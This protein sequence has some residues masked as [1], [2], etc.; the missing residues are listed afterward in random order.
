MAT[1]HFRR[2]NLDTS[3]LFSFLLNKY[4]LNRENRIIPNK[5]RFPGWVTPIFIFSGVA[6]GFARQKG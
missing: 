6:Q 1:I 2:C 5:I 4:F 3:L